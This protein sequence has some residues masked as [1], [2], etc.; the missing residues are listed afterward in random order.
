MCGD[1]HS[2]LGLVA[3]DLSLSLISCQWDGLRLF[4]PNTRARE[5]PQVKWFSKY[6][7]FPFCQ[8]LRSSLVN[9]RTQAKVAEE[10]GMQ[11][12]AITNDKT[13]RP[14]AL[15]TKTL[16]D[17][18][19]CESYRVKLFCNLQI[20]SLDQTDQ[21]FSFFSLLLCFILIITKETFFLF[22]FLFMLF[23]KACL[24][25]NN[26]ELRYVNRE[27]YVGCPP[28]PASAPMHPHLQLW[29]PFV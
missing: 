4:G 24:K 18:L 7:S 13:K 11:E 3:E 19:E 23:F 20:Q 16:A 10:L 9:N 28:F 22:W 17:L 26:L 21:H 27:F 6:T 25:E 2:C 12:Y 29:H 1:R 14:V 5:R 15:R 8:L